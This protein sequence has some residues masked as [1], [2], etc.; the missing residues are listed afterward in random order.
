V[1]IAQSVEFINVLDIFWIRGT[2]PED[3]D[4][5]LGGVKPDSSVKGTGMT[6]YDRMKSNSDS[7]FAL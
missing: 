7:G 3:D 4:W 2:A 1:R 5:R 6:A